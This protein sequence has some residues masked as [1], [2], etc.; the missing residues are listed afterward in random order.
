MRSI[1]I[2]YPEELALM[3]EALTAYCSAHGIEQGTPDYDEAGQRVL[4]LFNMGWRSKA[5]LVMMFGLHHAS[6]GMRPV[7][8]SPRTD[9]PVV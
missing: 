9:S 3:T 6:H 8:L 1:G 4:A 5:E 7:H 2:A